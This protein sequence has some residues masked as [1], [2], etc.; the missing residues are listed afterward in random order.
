MIKFCKESACNA[1]DS[2]Q[3]RR[4]RFDLGQ[5]D[6]LQKEVAS[7]SS[8]LAW[9]IPWAEEPG[10]L[11]SMES[12]RVRHHLATKPPSPSLFL[13]RLTLSFLHHVHVSVPYICV[14]IPA[15]K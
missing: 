10:R 9:E 7:H 11:H 14:S 8:I 2:L 12:Q 3:Y 4:H 15:W 13:I 5:E 6:S 1:G